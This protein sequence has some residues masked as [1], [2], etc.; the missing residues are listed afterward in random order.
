MVHDH[1][2]LD[3]SAGIGWGADSLENAGSC[4]DLRG[5]LLRL[6]VSTGGPLG[7]LSKCC[8]SVD[9]HG[10][11]GYQRKHINSDTCRHL[12]TA[13]VIDPPA[14][15]DEQTMIRT[16]T[17]KHQSRLDRMLLGS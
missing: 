8:S 3:S 5:L 14:M 1:F 9:Q 17:T 12:R 7:V 6:V 13:H 16:Q 15:M 4:Q 10:Q 2:T 11:F